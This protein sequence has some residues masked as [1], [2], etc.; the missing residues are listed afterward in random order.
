MPNNVFNQGSRRLQDRFE[1]RAAADRSQHRVAFTDDDRAFIEQRCC[2]FLATVD[3]DGS[4]DCSYKGGLPGFVRIV[5]EDTLVF[6]DY[7][8]NGQFRS[9]GNI[10]VNPQVGLL[11]L[12][13]ETPGRRRV[14]GIAAISEDDP[15]LTEY[16]DAQLIVRVKATEIFG[17][18]PRFVH[19]MQL[20]EPATQAPPPRP[21]PTA[22]SA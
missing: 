10:L 3:A 16:P 5:A 11:F 1:T 8:G 14:N 15:L 17:N 21:A 4:P 19:R 12:D 22:T 20:V 9:L 2:F 13:F 18:C 6:P 7:K